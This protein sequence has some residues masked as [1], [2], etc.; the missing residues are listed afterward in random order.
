MVT[1]I[2]LAMAFSQALPAA[3]AT[4]FGSRLNTTIQPSNAG[5]GRWCDEFTSGEEDPPHPTCTWILNEA[6]VHSATIDP[7]AHAR[8]P[9]DGYV[10]KVKVISCGPGSFRLQIAK[11]KRAVH[12]AK[13]VRQSGVLSYAGDPDHCDDE[14]YTVNTINLSPNLRVYKGQFLA[15]RA[16]QIGFLRCSSGGDNTLIFDPYLPV[17][18][19]YEDESTDDGC[20]MLLEAVMA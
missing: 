2:A 14:T 9:R 19:T 13:V 11:V 8:A 6:Y 3:A 5:Q 1:V 12:Q 15:V 20:W 7:R 17:G 18:G 10:D 16:K 4:K